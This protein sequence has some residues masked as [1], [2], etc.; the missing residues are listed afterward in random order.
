MGLPP[1]SLLRSSTD[2]VLHTRNFSP[3]AVVRF[4]H[5]DDLA[6][7]GSESETVVVRGVF[8]ELE[9]A[10]NDVLFGAS[11]GVGCS[12]LQS[13]PVGHRMG[14][15]AQPGLGRRPGASRR[16]PTK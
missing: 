1:K 2:A 16:Q 6:I 7:A 15:P 5:G 4:R 14:Q 9:L 11:V 8:V 10:G 12:A 3:E 13:D